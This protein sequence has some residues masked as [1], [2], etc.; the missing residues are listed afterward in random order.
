MQ[1]QEWM[2]QAACAGMHPVGHRDEEDIFFP[3]KGRGD[4]RAQAK[5]VCATCPVRAQCE[6]Y[7]NTTGSE[8][9]WGATD[10]RTAM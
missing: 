2:E 9:I 7:G 5:A 6:A 10:K 3:P 8:G 4:L 1:P